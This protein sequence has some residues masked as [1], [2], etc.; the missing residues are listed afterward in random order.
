MKFK[1]GDTVY[2]ADA[3]DT[4]KKAVIKCVHR[5]DPD[6]PYELDINSKNRF[7]P[8]DCVFAS[9]EEA[10]DGIRGDQQRRIT[11]AIKAGKSLNL[12]QNMP[13]KVKQ[14]PFF[15]A[16]EK[17]RL[18]L[19]KLCRAV[20]DYC[21]EHHLPFMLTVV[22]G[23]K[24]AKGGAMELVRTTSCFCGERTPTWLIELWEEQQAMLGYGD[25]DE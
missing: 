8:E 5:K 7:Y 23:R 17:E 2:Y 15:M 4:I 16:S 21:T 22:M 6:F 10:V 20:D 1:K 24:K 19:D 3:N 25:E 9:E 14:S 13:M 12:T 11:D 18:D